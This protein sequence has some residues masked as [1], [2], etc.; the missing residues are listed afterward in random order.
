M[1]VEQRSD[2]NVLTFNLS[3]NFC[4]KE[5]KKLD[6]YKTQAQCRQSF[7]TRIVNNGRTSLQTFT[8]IGATMSKRGI[9]G[10]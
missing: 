7:A 6:Y 1:E 8:Y 2:P 9:L 5:K 10:F 4:G 3:F